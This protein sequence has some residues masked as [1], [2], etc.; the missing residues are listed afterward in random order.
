MRQQLLIR[1]RRE[2]SEQTV[3][4]S[5]AALGIVLFGMAVT[6][7][8]LLMIGMSFGI[9]L[10]RP[11]LIAGWASSSGWSAGQIGLLAKLQMSC[12]SGSLGLLIGAL[13]ASFESQNYF[14][15]VIFVDE[16]I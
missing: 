12:F 6:W 9:L 10:F 2:I 15:H 7:I 4:T 13:G 1:R 3:V 8:S 11:A 14:R 16:E 5:V